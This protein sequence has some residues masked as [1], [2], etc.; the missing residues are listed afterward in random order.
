[1]KVKYQN[2][3]YDA[4]SWCKYVVMDSDGDIWGYAGK[5]TLLSGGKDFVAPQSDLRCAS[6]GFIEK[7]TGNIG[8]VVSV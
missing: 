6:L 1:M 2:E 7:P 5:P 8:L 3:T 4:P